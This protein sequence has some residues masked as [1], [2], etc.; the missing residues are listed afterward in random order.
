MMTARAAGFETGGFNPVLIEL[1][2]ALAFFANDNHGD[3]FLN[4]ARS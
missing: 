4:A 2:A 3:S 1:E